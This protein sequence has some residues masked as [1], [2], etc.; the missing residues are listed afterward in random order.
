MTTD[1]AR[2]PNP[3]RKHKTALQIK[4]DAG[5]PMLATTKKPADFF[6][7]PGGF[8]ERTSKATVQRR[9]DLY[10]PWPVAV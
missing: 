4:S 10:L 2:T 9:P 5:T 6:N 3:F 8:S 7:T 1:Q